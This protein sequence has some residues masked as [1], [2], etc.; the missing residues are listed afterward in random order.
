MFQSISH[1]FESLGG[2]TL[3]III[4]GF[5]IGSSYFFLPFI[6]F[7]QLRKIEEHAGN[8]EDIVNVLERLA[9]GQEKQVIL[10]RQ[11]LKAYGHE[12]EA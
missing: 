2:G 4:I 3:A 5:L 9:A 10:T 11:L 8:T 12:P 7:F 6:Y 1:W